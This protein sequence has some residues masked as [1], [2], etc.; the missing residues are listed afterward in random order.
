MQDIT[1]AVTRSQAPAPRSRLLEPP[2]ALL[3]RIFSFNPTEGVVLIRNDGHVFEVDGPTHR[4]GTGLRFQY[5]PCK[6]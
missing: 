4:T 1:I 5:K 6:H 3:G 2:L